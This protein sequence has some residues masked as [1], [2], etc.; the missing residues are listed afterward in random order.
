M[1]PL[2]EMSASGPWTIHCI[3]QIALPGHEHLEEKEKERG[4]VGCSVITSLRSRYLAAL[5]KRDRVVDGNC[6]MTWGH[7]IFG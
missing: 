2:S 1:V 4:R 7:R 5:F 6:K 3:A